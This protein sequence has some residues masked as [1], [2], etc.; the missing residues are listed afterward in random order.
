VAEACPIPDK[1]RKE[2][3]GAGVE[4]N[5]PQQQQVQRSC[6]ASYFIICLRKNW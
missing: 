5:I 3:V 6:G 4:E 1:I 2:E